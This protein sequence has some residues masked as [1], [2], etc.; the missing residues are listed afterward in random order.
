MK[1]LISLAQAFN[2]GEYESKITNLAE[3][4]FQHLIKVLKWDDSTNYNKHIRDLNGWLLPI[5]DMK[6]KFKQKPGDIERW[7]FAEAFD[8]ES[9]DLRIEVVLEDYHNLPEKMTN[10]QV[11]AKLKQIYSELDK[12]MYTRTFRSIKN[13]L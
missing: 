8:Q 10:Q 4:I 1:L 11:Y 7:L 9:V 3:P 13:Y 2:R 6:T 12:A 5:R